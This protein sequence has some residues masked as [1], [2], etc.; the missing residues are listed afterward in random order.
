MRRGAGWD[1]QDERD[2]CELLRRQRLKA[3]L[4]AMVKSPH[5]PLVEPLRQL[6][7]A[8]L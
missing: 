5:A 2:G 4:P 7:G 1:F 6:V 3:I 8:V